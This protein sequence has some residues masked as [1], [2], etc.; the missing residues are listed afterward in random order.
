ML[1]LVF[2]SLAV[3]IINMTAADSYYRIFQTYNYHGSNE[4]IGNCLHTES[5]ENYAAQTRQCE[6]DLQ[7]QQWYYDESTYQIKNAFDGCLT[8]LS[9]D[10]HAEARRG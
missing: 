2:L 9:G 7:E 8:I 3:I 1:Y 4:S 10:Y 5:T 6:E